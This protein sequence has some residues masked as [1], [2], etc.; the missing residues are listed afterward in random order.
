MKL[1][2]IKIIYPGNG[3]NYLKYDV[4]NG[5]IICQKLCNQSPYNL[6][7]IGY[8]YF[9]ELC[10]NDCSDLS[11][12]NNGR[13]ECPV[14]KPFI[15]GPNAHF[16]DLGGS[17]C[18]ET[19]PADDAGTKKYYYSGTNKICY[20]NACQL[21][22]DRR[23]SSRTLPSYYVDLYLW[24]AF[25]TGTKGECRSTCSG[26][27]MI[28]EHGICKCKTDYVWTT[29]GTGCIPISS[30]FAQG[31]LDLNL[32]KTLPNLFFFSFI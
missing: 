20:E 13:C 25:G 26:L 1:N 23:I 9:G 22:V 17:T 29:D 19:C 12:S 7:D 21:G 5:N 18:V 24:P 4:A 32:I 31:M 2:Y 14:A 6:I 8:P 28:N 3:N 15:S 30:C 27:D 16:S 11:T 10:V